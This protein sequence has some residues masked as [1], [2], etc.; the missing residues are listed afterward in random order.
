MKTYN[1][2]LIGMGMISKSHMDAIKNLPYARCAAVV[3]INEEKAKKGAQV[4]NCPYF[5]D[6]ADMLK[7]V[8]EVEICIIALPTYL[9]AQHVEL[10]A[11]AGKA[12][13]CE[14][15]LEINEHKA[16]QIKDI[17]SETGIIFMTAQ[18]VRFWTGYTDIKQMMD[19]GVI[20]D[21]YMSYFSRC[22][23]PQKWDNA[24]LF[25]PNRGGGALRDMMVHDVDYMNYLFGSTR[26]VYSIASKDDSGCYNNVFASITYKNGAKGVVETS[27]TMKNGY[28]FSMF[29]KLIGTG[30]TVEYTYRAGFDINQRSDAELCLKIYRD[31]HE[32]Q[33]ISPEPYDAYTKQLEYFINCVD[34]KKNPDIITLDQ[35]VEVIKTVDAIEQ[36][37]NTGS[38]ILFD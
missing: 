13:L 36:S 17:V 21:I 22:S 25:D 32:P 30:A 4:F 14:K 16:R 7:E 35:S 26:S 2:A 34:K 3:D 1:I 28:P 6:A 27:F 15:P 8:P 11:R 23:Q 37:A 33:I 9:H 19:S 5:T 29:A 12:V 18:V 20:G 10:C 38:V 31:G 24:W